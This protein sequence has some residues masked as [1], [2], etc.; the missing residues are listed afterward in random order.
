MPYPTNFDPNQSQQEIIQEIATKFWQ[1]SVAKF[2]AG[3]RDLKGSGMKRIDVFTPVGMVIVFFMPWLGKFGILIR[4]ANHPGYVT[5]QMPSEALFL[6]DNQ[7]KEVMD[8]AFMTCD[9][10]FAW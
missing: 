10:E 8:I 6:P 3:L 2:R 5:L 9:W 4:L 1:A 7:D